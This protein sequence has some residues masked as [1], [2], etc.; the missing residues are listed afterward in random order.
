M[1]AHV[2]TVFEGVMLERAD[3]RDAIGTDALDGHLSAEGNRGLARLALAD[4]KAL[5]RHCRLSPR[6]R[7]IL[8]GTAT[9]SALSSTSRIVADDPLRSGVHKCR[10]QSVD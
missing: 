8:A 6:S 7:R 3:D 4:P 2:Q 1:A 9:G 5:V 10:L